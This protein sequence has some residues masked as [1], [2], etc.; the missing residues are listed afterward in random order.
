MLTNFS[1]DC[2]PRF[3]R[4]EYKFTGKERDQESG[5]DYFNARYYSSSMGR[6]MSPDPVGGSLSNPQSLNRYAYVLNNPLIFTDPTD[7][8]CAYLGSSPSDTMVVRGD[9]LSD[10][11]D[12]VFVD[13]HI[14]NVFTGQDGALWA[15]VSA[16]TADN[17]PYANGTNGDIFLPGMMDQWNGSSLAQQVFQG[18]GSGVFGA[19]NTAVTD[20]AIGYAALAG[21][22]FFAPEIA[23]GA[24]A[25]ANPLGPAAGRVFWSGASSGGAA[26]AAYVAENGG[27]TLEATPLGSAANFVQNLPFVPSNSFTYAAWARLSTAYAQGA[28]GTAMYFQ[29]AG[30]YQ[31]QIWLNYEL[32]TLVQR[33][34]PIVTVPHP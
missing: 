11:D 10:D 17:D 26:A 31:G 27:T 20:A 15:N 18:P 8:D 29:G 32:P 6:M 4:F 5:N 28:T 23:A 13:G 33:G 21:G 25:V 1:Y 16:Y 3:V 34:V 12:G 9:C 30:G 14:D 2:T 7:L 19:A 24:S 22:V